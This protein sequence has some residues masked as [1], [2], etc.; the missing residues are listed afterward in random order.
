MEEDYSESIKSEDGDLFI[1]INKC[2]DVLK[3]KSSD[4][5]SKAFH[6]KLLVHFIG[7]L[8]QPLH[9]GQKEDR[10]GNRI[11]VKW[12]GRNTNLHSVWDS[13]MI[14]GYQM[15]YSEMAYNLQKSKTN[16]SKKFER[17]DLNRW[18]NEIHIHT[19]NIYK[20]LDNTSLGYEYQYKNFDLVKILLFKGGHRLAEILNYI[21]D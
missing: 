16:K 2:I 17:K 6:L 5:E 7:D 10:G 21:F 8:H 14:D 9:L 3:S 15:S 12:F 20:S 1:A 19:N 11:N 18:I 13:K 4:N